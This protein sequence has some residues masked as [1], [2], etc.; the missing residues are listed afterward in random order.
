MG[1]MNPSVFRQILEQSPDKPV[2]VFVPSRRQ[3]RITAETLV[4]LARNADPPVNWLHCETSNEQYELDVIEKISDPHLKET[5][6]RGVGMH[7]A[8]E[9]SRVFWTHCHRSGPQ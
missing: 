6:R 2:L 4:S 8:G 9:Y 1:S 3:T 7:N 5:L